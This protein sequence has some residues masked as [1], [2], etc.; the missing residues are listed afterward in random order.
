MTTFNRRWHRLAAAAGRAPGTPRPSDIDRFLPLEVSVREDWILPRQLGWVAAACLS[1]CALS[2]PWMADVLSA[3]KDLA[4]P[5]LTLPALPKPP[6]VP[7][8]PTLPDVYTLV[9]SLMSEES[10]R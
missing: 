6:R 4:P 10:L 9:Q 3:P 7:Q 1:A 2:L 8:P 5:A